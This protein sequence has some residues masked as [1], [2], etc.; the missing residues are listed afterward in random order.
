MSIKE[1]ALNCIRI[2]GAETNN[3]KSVDI[4][5]PRNQLVVI[6][7][8]SGS[9]KSSLAFDTIF[10]EGRRQFIEG[11]SVYTRRFLNQLPRAAVESIDGLQPTLAIDQQSGHDNPRSTVGTI[12]EIHDYLR[13]LMARCGEVHCYQCG[14]PIQQQ[15]VDQIR[16]RLMELPERTKLMVMS[17]L[18]RGRKGSHAAAFQKIR[19]ERLV[20]VRV[21]GEIHDI[22][23]APEL[24]P[25]QSHDIEA[26][27]DRII[28]REG[29]ESRLVESLE[30][31]TRLGDGLVTI[32][33]LPKGDSDWQDKTYSTKYACP[34]CEIDYEEVEPR[35]F[36]FNS[37]HGACSKC[38]GL[39]TIEGFDRSRV[40]DLS[41]SL[42]DGA[43]QCWSDVNADERKARLAQLEPCLTSIEFDLNTPLAKLDNSKLLQLWNGSSE[44]PVGIDLMMQKDLA[45]ATDKDRLKR[46]ESFRGNVSCP[47]CNG[48]RLCEQA[49]SVLLQGHSISQISAMPIKDAVGFFQGVTF[50]DYRQTIA[51]PLL[52]E[53]S[54]RLSYLETVGVG[55]LGLSRSGRTLSGGE[56]QRVRLATAIGA[57]LTCVCFVLDEPSIGLHQRDNQRL[58][59]AVIRLRDS[60]N[61]VIV[62]EHDEEIMRVA[63]HL[64]DVGPAAG[65]H[66][67]QIVA[68]GSPE[69][70][71]K[72]PESPTGKFLIGAEKISRSQSVREPGEAWL[73]LKGARGN[74]LKNVDLE[75]PLGLFTCVTGVSGS[76]KSTLLNKTLVPA[77]RKRLGLLPGETESYQTLEGADNVERLIQVDQRPFGRTSRGCA[78]TYTGVFEELRKIYAKTKEAKQMGFTASRFS[79]NAKS[80]HCS[81][82]QGHGQRKVKMSFLPDIFVECSVCEGKRFNEQTLQVRFRGMTIAD[83]LTLSI[84]QAI[85]EFE[86]IE[87]VRVVLQCLVDV[88]LGYLSLGQPSSTLSGGEAQRI[89]LATELAKPTLGHTVYIMDEPTTGLHFQD[90]RRLLGVI[91]QLVDKGNTVIV[92]EHNLD[93]I[94]C[95]DWIVDVGPEG[96]SAGGTI[97][98]T[99]PPTAIANAANSHTGRFLNDYL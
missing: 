81:E 1:E 56:H 83:V 71:M 96:G 52:A 28:I 16:D 54:N 19:D 95:A 32:S 84:D 77:L 45:T 64:I 60:G 11:Q 18:V 29:I 27:T 49:N 88:G 70:V 43:I 85:R 20:R 98:A 22:E 14:Q 58:I 74:N 17:P 94:K 8:V 65:K 7:G 31:A 15:T 39:G 78:A 12:T 24:A 69:E 67:G 93:V 2:R 35:T 55:Y 90:I 76:G 23:Q 3:L 53:L 40:L 47:A 34:A 41:K 68:E 37:P 26:V 33:S 82:C 44:Y 9:G 59:D 30:L 57:G 66:G 72:N 5:I 80:G 4:D 62:V 79:F 73:R 36:S 61:T 89:K 91:S 50:T 87:K 25:N 10:S 46:L 97:V 21:D 99:G 86:N 38:T 13:V 42:A 51:E 48:S 75:I 63:D 92:I 6:T